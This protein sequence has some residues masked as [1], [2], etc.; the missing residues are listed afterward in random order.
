MAS[1]IDMV[2]TLSAGSIAMLLE[3]LAIVMGLVI[4]ANLQSIVT[5]TAR[6]KLFVRGSATLRD[7]TWGLGITD[8]LANPRKLFKDW[9][10]LLAFALAVIVLVLEG[11]TVLQTQPGDSCSF[12][13]E[14]TWN[15]EKQELGCYEYSR[16]E[17]LG[18]TS[19]YF[20]QALDKVSEVDV[21]V[22]IPVNT[23]VFENSI[24]TGASVNS[25]R[26]HEERYVAPI[27]KTDKVSNVKVERHARSIRRAVEEG[28]DLG[29]TACDRPDALTRSDLLVSASI[30]LE[31]TSKYSDVTSSGFV[32]AEGACN[33]NFPARVSALPIFNSLSFL[34]RFSRCFYGQ[35]VTKT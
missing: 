11:L 27:L 16:A 18:L 10:S 12:Q 15:I 7:T 24:L 17:E 26:S 34:T 6:R 14:S 13:A 22:G 8:G 29:V 21:D 30:G 2:G 31:V 20:A 3:F 4:A 1:S 23:D 28:R 35:V 5:L 32:T 25:L 19:H 9:R 33:E